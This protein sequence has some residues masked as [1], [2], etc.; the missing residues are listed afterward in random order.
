MTIGTVKYYNATTGFGAIT[1]NN[2]T[3]D[4]L[5]HIS[6]IERAGMTSLIEG[7]QLSYDLQRNTCGKRQAVNLQLV[8]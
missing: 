5:V 1:P 2:G 8:D 3:K 4:A 7:L 6:D